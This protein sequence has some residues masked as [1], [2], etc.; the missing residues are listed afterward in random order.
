MIVIGS[1]L[2][3]VSPKG[4]HARN[5]VLGLDETDLTYALKLDRN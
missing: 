4:L 3:G 1:R 5:K 2:L